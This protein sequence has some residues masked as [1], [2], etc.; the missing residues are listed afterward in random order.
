MR[1]RRREV[2]DSAAIIAPDPAPLR[3]LAHSAF[4]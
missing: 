4:V 3:A 1:T 2:I